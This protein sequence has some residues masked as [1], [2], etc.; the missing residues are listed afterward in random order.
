MFKIATQML[1]WTVFKNIFFSMLY[2]INKIVQYCVFKFPWA[3]KYYTEFLEFT[4]PNKQTD[5]FG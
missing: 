4:D 1:P 2:C 3:N 5:P